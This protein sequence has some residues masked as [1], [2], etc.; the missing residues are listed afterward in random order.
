MDT[1]ELNHLIGATA[2]LMEQFERNCAE[3]ARREQALSQQLQGLS[4]QLPATVRQSADATL[5]RLPSEL[6]SKVQNGLE[7]PVSEYQKRLVEAGTQLGNGSQA[8]AQQLQRMEGL[9]RRLIW[10]SMAAVVGCMSVLLV[11]GIWLSMHYAGVI[12]HNQ[13]AGDKLKAIN[14]ADMVVCGER[15]CARI[16]RQAQ[17]FGE[18]GQYSVVR[19]R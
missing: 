1:Q 5:H 11:G 9:H 10:K 18:Q 14:A 19:Q 15:L 13:L 2:A 12:R 7:Q 16:D 6:L 3:I 17:G 8:L 4:Q